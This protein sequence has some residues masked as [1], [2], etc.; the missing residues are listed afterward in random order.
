MR[1]MRKHIGLGLIA[2]LM[3]ACAPQEEVK[4]AA[5][6]ATEGK[7]LQEVTITTVEEMNFEH[8]FNVHGTVEVEKN[9]LVFPQAGGRIIDI[10]VTEGAKVSKGQVIATIDADVLSASMDE[11]ATQLGLAKNAFEKQ[12]RLWKKQ[13]GSEMQFLQAKTNY[14]GLQKKMETLKKQKDQFVLRAPFAGV[15]DEI[16]PKVGEMAAPQMQFC[17]VINLN[18]VY[19]KADVSE[20]YIATVKAGTKVKVNFPSLNESFDARVARVGNF[21]NKGNRTFK[22]RVNMAN[23]KGMFK[24]NMLA[25]VSV[26]DY[27]KEH[28]D[29]VAARLIHQDRTGQEFIYGL[30]SDK[31]V[32]RINVQSGMSQNNKTIIIKGLEPEKKAG[33]IVIIDK[34]AKSVQ[35]GQSVEVKK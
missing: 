15:V 16:F 17:R 19:I 12:D 26:R 31:K 11:I 23:K 22:I 34:G 10:K 7:G 14:E 27:Y 13:I 35:A 25:D 8:Y 6:S 21:I 18:E 33:P 1:T 24:P 29:V 20:D 4:D 30:T 28:A 32:T 9:A 5:V 2:S 3:V